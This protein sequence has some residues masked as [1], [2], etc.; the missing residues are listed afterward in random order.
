MFFI[1]CCF[2]INHEHLSGVHIGNNPIIGA[3]S[4]VTKDIPPNVI[5]LGT[6]AR[7]LREIT[8]DDDIYY[9]NGQLISEN[10]V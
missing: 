8:T 1:D 4:I 5:A 10:M 9:E 7:I 3:G 6:P 2:F